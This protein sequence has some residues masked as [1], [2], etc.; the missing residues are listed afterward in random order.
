LFKNSSSG[1]KGWQNR[2]YSWAPEKFKNSGSGLLI[3]GAALLGTLL[4]Q[5]MGVGGVL[6]VNT[7]QPRT[8]LE[9]WDPKNSSEMT[10]V[11]PL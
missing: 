11:T 8:F 10:A 9:L 4:A 3:T 7:V 2:L 5:N 6:G 1:Y